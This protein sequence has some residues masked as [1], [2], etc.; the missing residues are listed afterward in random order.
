MS[1]IN[2]P[3]I[4]SR[5]NDWLSRIT[6]LYNFV[7]ETLEDIRD[8][9]C[10]TT[11]NVVMHEELMKKFDV[12][13]TNVPILDI[14]RSGKILAT[15]KPIGLWVIGANGRIDILTKGGAFILVDIAE[16][17]EPPIWKV[18]SPTNRK[19]G[20]AFEANF[21]FELVNSL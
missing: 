17:N 15:F 3:Y 7:R 20:K 14:T 16:K 1:D 9:E 8:V 12:P 10:V 21:I 13:P 19:Q 2:K 18:Y 5:V 6:G 4:E 11:K